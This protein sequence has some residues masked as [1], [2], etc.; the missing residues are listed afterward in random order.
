MNERKGAF[1]DS[2]ADII[3]FFHNEIRQDKN[4]HYIIILRGL[5]TR[6]GKYLAKITRNKVKRRGK[7]QKGRNDRGREK[8]KKKRPN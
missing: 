6:K 3:L 1:V 7:R 4:K 5:Q 2:C 8:K